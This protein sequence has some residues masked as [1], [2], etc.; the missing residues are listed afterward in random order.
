MASVDRKIAALERR[1]TTVATVGGIALFIA[2][3]LGALGTVIGFVYKT[4][5]PATI[6][7]AMEC[8]ADG[9]LGASCLPDP[10][11]LTGNITLGG[12]D[13]SLTCTDN[14]TFGFE[15]LPAI[16]LDDLSDVVV[17]SP[18]DGQ[19]LTYNETT[20]AWVNELRLSTATFGDNDTSAI[21]SATFAAV[22]AS[23]VALVT[24]THFIWCSGVYSLSVDS[25]VASIGVAVDDVVSEDS[26]LTVGVGATNGTNGIQIPFSIADQLTVSALS[27]LV[28]LRAE[29]DAGTLTVHTFHCQTLLV[30]GGSTPP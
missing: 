10:L 25:A 16:A 30:Q 7:T 24:G 15:C 26:T 21:M 18:A 11:P 12:N 22:G 3:A 13:T 19:V 14:T 27:S 5:P 29:T 23:S 4:Q 1:L 28:D 9:V 6:T 8:A 17:E 2:I 20:G